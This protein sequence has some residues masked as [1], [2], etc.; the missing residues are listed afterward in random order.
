[1]RTWK[2]YEWLGGCAGGLAEQASSFASC[3]VA[4]HRRVSGSCIGA[5]DETR[6][7]LGQNCPAFAVEKEAIGLV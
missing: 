5:V 6:T 3:H 4:V 2:S 1:M 7:V